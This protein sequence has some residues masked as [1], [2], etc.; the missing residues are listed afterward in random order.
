MKID[1][2]LCFRLR[3]GANMC[4]RCRALPQLERL[5]AIWMPDGWTPATPTI[6]P[7]QSK[8]PKTPPT[9]H[10]VR[11]DSDR[12]ERGRLGTRPQSAPTVTSDE[13]EWAIDGL[14]PKPS[15]AVNDQHVSHPTNDQ[16]TDEGTGDAT[17]AFRA[18]YLR[19]LDTSTD[20]PP[21]RPC[22]KKGRLAARQ[23]SS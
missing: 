15:A 8:Q 17:S 2:E 21:R 19:D 1:A 3:R 12:V 13:D 7:G 23:C 18:D 22:G 14:E 6:R 10:Q 16:T 4:P 20:A 11:S 9:I 5:L